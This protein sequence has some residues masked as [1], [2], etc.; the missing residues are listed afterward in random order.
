MF[1][2][3]AIRAEALAKV[4]YAIV[5]CRDGSY[6]LERGARARQLLVE[7]AEEITRNSIRERFVFEPVE[8][9]DYL[10]T[11]PTL[12]HTYVEAG[13]LGSA[14]SDAVRMRLHRSIM[15][16]VVDLLYAQRRE[17]TA[18]DLLDALETTLRDDLDPVPQFQGT[19]LRR[20]IGECRE[21]V[22]IET[23]SLLMDALMSEADNLRKLSHSLD[24]ADPPTATYAVRG[25]RRLREAASLYRLIHEL[26]LIDDF[27][28]GRSGASATT[29]D[30]P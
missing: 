5:C 15:Q 23:L 22:S 1:D 30:S 10:A 28:N 14:I 4:G 7:E 26:D 19:R 18:G 13:D 6:L 3:E 16:D 20:L 9:P 21:A 11:I 29:G 17:E 2:Y 27:C 12:L 24:I 25:S 8:I